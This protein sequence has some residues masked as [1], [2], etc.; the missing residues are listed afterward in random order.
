MQTNLW[1][2][3]VGLLPTGRLIK[4]NVTAV[5]GDGSYTIATND[6]STIR[7]RPQPGQVWSVPD[8]VFVLDGYI[9]D[10]APDLPGITQYV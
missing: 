2:E 10:Q 8:G 3:L 4:G 9:V 6:G 7:A 1:R 5:N